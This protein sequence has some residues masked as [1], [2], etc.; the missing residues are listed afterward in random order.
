MEDSRHCIDEGNGVTSSSAK[1]AGKSL[2]LLA[3]KLLCTCLAIVGRAR[4][5]VVFLV[6]MEGK[7]DVS[8][9]A[10]GGTGR[11]KAC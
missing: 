11:F 6:D 10:V 7:I 9:F 5:N 2:L 8:S 3:L 4:L 1:E